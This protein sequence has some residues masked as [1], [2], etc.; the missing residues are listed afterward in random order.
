MSSR[1]A[2]DASAATRSDDVAHT[3]PGRR[4]S[5]PPPFV[6][7]S[8]GGD[9]GENTSPSI[10]LLAINPAGVATVQAKS[11]RSIRDWIARARN[12][13]GA[14]FGACVAGEIRARAPTQS[15]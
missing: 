15:G 3:L 14:A 5:N 6:P 4:A 12:A 1:S 9:S 8:A 13:L 2:R 10:H 11:R 7:K